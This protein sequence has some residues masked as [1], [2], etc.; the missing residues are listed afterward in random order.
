MTETSENS[1]GAVEEALERDGFYVTRTSG[2]SMEPLFR[3][4]RD[5]VVISKADGELSKYDIA[6]YPSRDGRYVLHRVVGK[7]GEVYLIRGDNTYTLE[8]VPRSSVI[9]VVTSFN[10]KGRQY[11]L[12]EI[13]YKLYSRFWNFIYPVRYCLFK[14]RY[15]L[16]R[17]KHKLFK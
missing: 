10:R 2:V 1:R 14:I 16:S 11:N 15:F 13:S 3:T 6:L 4:H 8:R 17:I 5:A 9:G 12:T 7:K